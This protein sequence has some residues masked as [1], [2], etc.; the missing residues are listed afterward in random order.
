MRTST[1]PEWDGDPAE[2]ITD[3]PS[4]LVKPESTVE[5]IDPTSPVD[6]SEPAEPRQTIEIKLADDHIVSIAATTFWG[7]DGK[8]ISARDFIKRMFWRTA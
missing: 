6:P 5:P 7:P 3:P 8:P 2:I 4:H 1:N